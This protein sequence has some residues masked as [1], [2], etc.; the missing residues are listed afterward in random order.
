MPQANRLM[1][2][3]IVLCIGLLLSIG[4]ATQ[5]ASTAA[6]AHMGRCAVSSATL[7]SLDRVRLFSGVKALYVAASG[8]AKIDLCCPDESRL[9][10]LPRDAMWEAASHGR[11]ATGSLSGG[12]DVDGTVEQVCDAFYPKR[13][14][15]GS[16]LGGTEDGGRWRSRCQGLRWECSGSRYL[17]LD[18]SYDDGFNLSRGRRLTAFSVDGVMCAKVFDVYLPFQPYGKGWLTDGADLYFKSKNVWFRIRF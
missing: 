12:E 13:I 1:V 15:Y 18:T 17:L 3:R 10:E 6:R 14:D 2:S 4:C 8:S 7:I 5:S 11:D 16:W 9:V